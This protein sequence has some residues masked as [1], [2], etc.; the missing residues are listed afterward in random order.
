MAESFDSKKRLLSPVK[1]GGSARRLRLAS[2]G[3][4]SNQ[5]SA[6]ICK[7][8]F[9]GPNGGNGGEKYYAHSYL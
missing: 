1:T 7:R 5:Q 4:A 3:S 8:S 2:S 6:L 9:S